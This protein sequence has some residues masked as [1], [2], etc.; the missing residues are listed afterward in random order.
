MFT[1]VFTV[2]LAGDRQPSPPSY[3]FSH[4]SRMQTNNNTPAQWSNTRQGNFRR[5]CTESTMKSVRNGHF[6]IEHY[7]PPNFILR[8]TDIRRKN[9][10]NKAGYPGARSSKWH[11][12]AGR[13]GSEIQKLAGTRLWRVFTG[14]NPYTGDTC[15]LLLVR[16]TCEHESKM[17]TISPANRV[18]TVSIL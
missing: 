16:V 7:R 5:L 12:P 2:F 8:G 3:I 1:A 13:G 10:R 15:L 14:S 18:R 11:Y 9:R 17:L 6:V 4:Y